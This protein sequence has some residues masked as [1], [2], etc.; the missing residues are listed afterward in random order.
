MVG[1]RARAET[2]SDH[3]RLSRLGV[4]DAD[5]FHVRHPGQDTGV[6]L[7]QMTDADHSQP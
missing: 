1:E 6:F 3:L 5:Q 4:H 7:A 2:L